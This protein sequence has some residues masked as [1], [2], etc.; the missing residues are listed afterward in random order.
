MFAIVGNSLVILACFLQKK[1][2]PLI[3]YIHVLAF[4]DLFYALLAPFYTYRYVLQY[5]PNL[6]IN[7]SLTGQLARSVAG[8]GNAFSTTSC[9]L[10]VALT[11]DRLILTRFPFDAAKLSTTKRAY[12]SSLAIGILSFAF[13]SVWVYEVFDA[14]VTILPC[15][16][17]YIIP[18]KVTR[19]DGS[20]YVPVR[21]RSEYQLYSVISA[22]L[23]LY[24]IPT[25]VMIACNIV[26][27]RKFSN[28]PIKS[29]SAKSA[30]LRS[31][32]ASER[33]LTKMIVV[34]SV[35]FMICNLPDIITRL[36]WKFLPPPIVS[37][38]QPIAH[39]FLM[40]NVAANF[41]VYSLFN[42]HLFTTIKAMC[43]CHH[44]NQV[45]TVTSSSS[46]SSQPKTSGNSHAHS[47]VNLVT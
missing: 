11:I 45:T 17:Y 40:I 31:K 8:I 4:S 1:R 25:I 20:V 28:N 36:L 15:N 27:I 33:R 21:H 19:P 9:W 23:F 18:N 46:N 37:K 42:K 44:D 35:L 5:W 3:I 43:I 32:Q 34:V 38:V 26:I 14:P 24:G 2:P 6:I 47:D 13:N 41:I 29:Q 39:L 30:A 7:F 16:G 12:L 22:T 10:V